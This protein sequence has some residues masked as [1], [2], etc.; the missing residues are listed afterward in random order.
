MTHYNKNKLGL[1]RATLEINY[2][3]SFEALVYPLK[4]LKLKLKKK[5]WKKN[6]Y[7]KN[8]SRFFII[9]LFINTF[10]FLQVQF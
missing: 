7:K 4:S 6:L 10:N 5:S 1:S 9:M 2:R 8:V 3:F